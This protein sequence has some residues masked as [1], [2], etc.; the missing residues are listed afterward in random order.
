MGRTMAHPH[1][2]SLPFPC[3]CRDTLTLELRLKED[4]KSLAHGKV[5]LSETGMNSLLL[6]TVWLVL[7]GQMLTVAV[8]LL[9]Y[10]HTLGDLKQLRCAITKVRC[11]WGFGLEEPWGL[12][13]FL[14][15]RQYSCSKPAVQHF[16]C[17]EPCWKCLSPSHLSSHH[18]NI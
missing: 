9:K 6:V 3:L 10:N 18:T 5:S 14:C 12:A 1:K 15:C 11:C 8:L 16:N 4:D 13:T 7:Q 2:Y 17:P